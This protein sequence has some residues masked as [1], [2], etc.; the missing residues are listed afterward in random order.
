MASSD[1]DDVAR[2][3]NQLRPDQTGVISAGAGPPG[4]EG[5]RGSK[6]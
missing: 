6:R 5:V 4:L 1:L 3:I 2:L